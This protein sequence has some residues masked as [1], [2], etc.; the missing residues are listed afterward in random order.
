MFCVQRFRS[1]AWNGPEVQVCESST[2][3]FS[4]SARHASRWSDVE[5]RGRL[6]TVAAGV[7]EELTR[8]LP[9]TRDLSHLMLCGIAL[10]AAG[11][12]SN[13]AGGARARAS[14]K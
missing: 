6:V 3:L 8:Q 11:V 2:L 9:S 12:W 13:G 5:H 4:E 10:D 14:R 1:E 7:N